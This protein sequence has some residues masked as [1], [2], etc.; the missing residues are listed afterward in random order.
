M[1]REWENAVAASSQVNGRSRFWSNMAINGTVLIQQ[2]VSV[3]IIVWGVFLVAEGRITIGGLIAANILAGRVLAPLGAIAQTIFRAQYAFKSLGALNDFMAL[4]VERA[5]P[6][7]SDA[8]VARGALSLQAVSFTYPEAQRPALDGLS[9]E[10]SPGDCVALLGR[11]GSGKTT[12]G[13][14]ICG[15]ITPQSGT[16]LVDGIAQAQYDPAELRRGIGYLPQAPELFTGTLRE[17]LVI[18]APQA[19]DAEIKRALYFA[20]MDEFVAELSEGLDLFLGEQGR[21]LSGGQRQGVALARL[22]LRNPRTLFL[23]EPTNAMDQRMQAQ[24]IERL[25]ELNRSGVGMI[26]STHRQSL[27]A[28]ARRLIVMDRGRALLDGPRAEV[29]QKL[30]A[31]GAAR[32]EG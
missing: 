17:N 6:V 8:V 16:V 26:I 4:P 22:L 23:D 24:I 31:M 7:A 18:G 14:L 13:K 29:L 3:L 2:A 12:A 20:A 21:R 1:Q 32:A 27:A 5:G 28:M 15:L 30:R 25:D 11:V 19:S 10:F 9:F